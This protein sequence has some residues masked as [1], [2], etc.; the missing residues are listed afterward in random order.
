MAR[1]GCISSDTRRARAKPGV[2]AWL[3]DRYGGQMQA[4]IDEA[5]QTMKGWSQ[6]DFDR[7]QAEAEAIEAGLAKALGD[8]LPAD[9]TAVQALI[10]RQH[11]WVG[12]SWNPPADPRGLHRSGRP[13]PGEP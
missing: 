13:L 5:K 11:A 9:S 1:R 6:A 7:L 3:V 2:E 8:G 4:R 12:A 10:R